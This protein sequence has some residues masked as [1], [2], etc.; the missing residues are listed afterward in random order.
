[1]ADFESDFAIKD[2]AISSITP[3]L[4]NCLSCFYYI[5]YNNDFFTPPDFDH[6]RALKIIK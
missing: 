4:K 1:M 6:K 2:S 3:E 5:D